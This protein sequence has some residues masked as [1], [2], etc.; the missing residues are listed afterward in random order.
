[1]TL[2]LGN[3]ALGK[4]K[5]K[6]EVSGPGSDLFVHPLPYLRTD[7][8]TGLPEMGGSKLLMT[9]VFR[10]WPWRRRLRALEEYRE[11]LQRPEHEINLLDCALL[12]AKH[13]HPQMVRQTPKSVHDFCYGRITSVF[14]VC[15]SILRSS[16][17]CLLRHI[18]YMIM[19]LLRMRP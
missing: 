7:E 2:C 6:V 8:R 19:P 1:M 13:A 10:G 16:H 11:H 3:R 12:I 4:P 18:L 17:H 14:S 5:G 9:I 15:D